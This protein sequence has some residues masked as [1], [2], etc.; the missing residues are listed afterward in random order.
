MLL[1]IRQPTLSRK[2]SGVPGFIAVLLNLFR[3]QLNAGDAAKE[4][5]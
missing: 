5:R 2:V 1:A 3:N 4:S